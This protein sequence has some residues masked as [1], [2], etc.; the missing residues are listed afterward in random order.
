MQDICAYLQGVKMSDNVEG[1]AG[2]GYRHIQTS[3]VTEET[4]TH[5]QH[6]VITLAQ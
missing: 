3:I 6:S 5:M 4:A 2:S 1:V